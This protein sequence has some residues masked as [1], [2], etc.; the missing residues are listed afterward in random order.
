[1][2]IDKNRTVFINGE[3]TLEL[4]GVIARQIIE[5]AVTSVEEPIYVIINSNGGIVR[6]LR[7]IIAALKFSTC[8]IIMIII[9][10]ARS[11][12]AI[13][14]LQG[15]ERIML[16]GSELLFH[17]PRGSYIEVTYLDMKSTAKKC[18]KED[19]FFIDEIVRMTSL[20]KKS[21]KSRITNKHYILTPEEALKI[22]AATKIITEISKL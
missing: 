11:S 22:G 6:A 18:K 20:S 12:A 1:M 10:V 8:K 19:D 9:G 13:L 15:D 16:E 17:E 4:S 14:F 7:T 3:F 5:L 21:V 2:A